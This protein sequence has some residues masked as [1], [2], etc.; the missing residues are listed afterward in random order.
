MEWSNVRGTRTPGCIGRAGKGRAAEGELCTLLRQHCRRVTP[1]AA[2][3][4]IAGQT[5][6][7]VTGCIRG[8]STQHL[9]HNLSLP[10]SFASVH[11]HDLRGDRPHAEAP[12]ADAT[13]YDVG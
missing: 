6:L 11:L 13:E 9:R 8:A 5:G 7:V 12:V 10:A 2:G 1:G 4:R 3:L